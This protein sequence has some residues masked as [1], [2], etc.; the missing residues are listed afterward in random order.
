MKSA[1]L[2]IVKNSVLQKFFKSLGL[3]NFVYFGNFYLRLSGSSMRFAHLKD[4]TFEIT[5][6]NHDI[7]QRIW[8]SERS[9]VMNYQAG[10]GSRLKRL[11]DDYHIPMV[12]IKN[13]DT[14]IDCGA[15]I[16]EI[17]MCLRQI[18]PAVTHIAFEPSYKDYMCCGKN[19]PQSVIKKLGLWKTTDKLQ[20][21][22]KTDTA[23]SSLI[24]TGDYDKILTIDVVDLD[25]FLEASEIRNVKLLK[26]EAEGAEPEILEGA[27]RSLPYIEYISVDAGPERG[28]NSESTLP[29]VTN[30]L[31]K[32]SFE[33]I[34]INQGRLT[35]LYRNTRCKL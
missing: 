18:A 31:L 32:N 3:N 21:F 15:N 34:A 20:F 2:N 17:G 19:N 14:V 29:Q 26:L 25:T 28:I 7:V 30:F 23:D 9:R 11:S 6:R 24:E 33:M 1:T 22:L 4:D 12:G 35:A 8:I 10:L 16:G 13:G 27:A 5:F